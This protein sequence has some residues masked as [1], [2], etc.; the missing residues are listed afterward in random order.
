MPV[1]R[2]IYY[3][4]CARY[5]E[6]KQDMQLFSD[7]GVR[8]IDMETSAVLL[9]S[10]FHGIAASS[11]S[12]VMDSPGGESVDTGSLGGS[13]FHGTTDHNAYQNNVGKRVRSLINSAKRVYEIITSRGDY[14]LLVDHPGWDSARGCIKDS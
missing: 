4:N 12:V 2:G 11:V 3:T 6:D 13:T 10:F 1:H 8:F 14:S 9:V 5:R 7:G